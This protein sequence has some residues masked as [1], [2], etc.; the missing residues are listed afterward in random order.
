[1]PVPDIRISDPP[2]TGQKNPDASLDRF[3]MKK[4]FFYDPY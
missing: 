2:N 4:I 3:G 1:M